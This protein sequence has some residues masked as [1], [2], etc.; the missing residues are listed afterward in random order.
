VLTAWSAESGFLAML[1]L[2]SR[3]EVL[4]RGFPAAAVGAALIGASGN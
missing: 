3:V 4:P 1:D 2:A